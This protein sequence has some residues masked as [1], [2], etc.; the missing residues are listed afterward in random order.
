LHRLAGWF[1][2]YLVIGGM[3]GLA[4]WTPHRSDATCV[5]YLTIFL[6]LQTNCGSELITLFWTLV[7]GIPRSFM[8]PFVLTLALFKAVFTNG[9]NGHSYLPNAF[10]WMKISVPVLLL[11][12]AGI[13]YWWGCNRKLAIITGAFLPIAVAI[14]VFLK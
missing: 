1:L 13:S 8:I 7:V 9:V 5:P 11:Y 10:H 14:L 3:I 6:L 12:S 4:F 2:L